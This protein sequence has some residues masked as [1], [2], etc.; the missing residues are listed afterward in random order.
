MRGSSNYRP[1][2][3]NKK[4]V[5]S[6]LKRTLGKVLALLL[7]FSSLFMATCAQVSFKILVSAPDVGKPNLSIT[8]VLIIHN[9][10]FNVGGGGGGGGG[11]GG[12]IT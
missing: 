8:N 3:M 11:R 2:L 6:C 12:L 9:Y 5:Q 1:H 10:C 7:H 4:T